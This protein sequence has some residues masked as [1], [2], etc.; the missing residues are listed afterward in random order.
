MKKKN[1]FLKDRNKSM[2]SRV[3]K[4][5]WNKSLIKITIMVN[6]MRRITTL[7]M[8]KNKIRRKLKTKIKKLKIEI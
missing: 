2:F 4:Q 6:L 5:S 7:I 1:T 3:K 8:K